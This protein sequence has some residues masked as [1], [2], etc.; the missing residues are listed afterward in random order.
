VFPLYHCYLLQR[1][2]PLLLVVL[3]NLYN[4]A[5]LSCATATDAVIT[6]TATGGTGTITYSKD[7]GQF[8]SFKYIQRSHRRNLPIKVRMLIHP[9]QP[10]VSITA[11][12]HHYY[13][14]VKLIQWR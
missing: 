6:V 7:N 4:G 8:P 5:D 1:L 10:V 11:P 2:P 14:T 3:L 13:S 12:S 9:L